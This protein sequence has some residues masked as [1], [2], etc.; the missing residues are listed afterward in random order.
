[1]VHALT[2]SWRV[3]V[4]GGILIDIRPIIC[5]PSI[6]VLLDGEVKIA[7]QMDDSGSLADHTAADRAVE[8]AVSQGLFITKQAKTPFDFTYYW[9]SLDLMIDYITGRWSDFA[10]LPDEV[11]EK[12]KALSS[13]TTSAR[14]RVNKEMTVAYF[15]KE[16]P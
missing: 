7:G 8:T 11:I 4:P 10:T 2:E 16:T 5:H 14:F 9:E 12:A 1:M 15:Q 3:L 13:N 6:E